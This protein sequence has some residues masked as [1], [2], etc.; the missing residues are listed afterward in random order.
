MMQIHRE[1]FTDVFAIHTPSF[2]VKGEGVVPASVTVVGRTLTQKDVFIIRYENLGRGK[3]YVDKKAAMVRQYVASYIL[4]KVFDIQENEF[5]YYVS[6]AMLSKKVTNVTFKDI[7]QQMKNLELEYRGLEEECGCISG[8]EAEEGAFC[9]NTTQYWYGFKHLIKKFGLTGT[10]VEQAVSSL[11]QRLEQK[12]LR[13]WRGLY[14]LSRELTFEEAYEEVVEIL[15]QQFDGACKGNSDEEEPCIIEDRFNVGA[16]AR[17]SQLNN[18]Y[19][20]FLAVE[21]LELAFEWSVTFGSF[22]CVHSDAI[23]ALCRNNRYHI[24]EGKVPCQVIEQIG[25]S[26][27]KKVLLVRR[28]EWDHFVRLRE[29]EARQFRV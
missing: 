1:I 6:K 27:G 4:G 24:S 5:G 16:E 22:Q 12:Q 13:A 2:V 18:Q 25:T 26:R 17:W 28:M 14:N 20:Q 7:H 19:E 15:A 8:C 10:D 11:Y 3:V 9:P 23:Y 21:G 29:Y